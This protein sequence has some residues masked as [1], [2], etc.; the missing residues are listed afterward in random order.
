MYQYL[1]TIRLRNVS[2]IRHVSNE[3]I[4]QI[5]KARRSLWTDIRERQ[6]KFIGH[7]MRKEELEQI[8]MTGKIQGKKAR[9]RQKQMM[10]PSMAEDYAM[11]TNDMLH[12]AKDR[13]KW[14]AMTTFAHD[15]HGT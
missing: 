10:L 13:R 9:G 14:K 11:K 5:A 3:E 4:L 8:L 1:Y 2:W 6:R 7:V 12:A 15:G